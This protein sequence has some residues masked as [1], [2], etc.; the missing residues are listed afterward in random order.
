M[1]RLLQWVRGLLF[2]DA[3]PTTHDPVV[4][5]VRHRDHTHVHLGLLSV[6][7][8]TMGMLYGSEAGDHSE[9]ESVI[10]RHFPEGEAM[11]T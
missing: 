9:V 3:P 10:G 8:D 6:D 1:K 5:T 7:A 2:E 4:V 11:T